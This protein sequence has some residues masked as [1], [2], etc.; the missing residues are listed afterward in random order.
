M[1]R[2]AKNYENEF[3]K[4]LA[5]RFQNTNKFCDDDLNKFFWRRGNVIGMQEKD[6]Q[7]SD[8]GKD[9]KC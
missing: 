5:N 4:D 2:L 8:N 6:L 9:Y 3:G 7:H 1:Y